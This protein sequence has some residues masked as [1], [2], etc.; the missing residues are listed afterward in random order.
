MMIK[1]LKYD[2]FIIMFFLLYVLYSIKSGFFSLI[3]NNEFIFQ[4]KNFINVFLIISSVTSAFLLSKTRTKFYL[5]IFTILSI[6]G[7][8]FFSNKSYLGFLLII[9]MLILASKIKW[10]NILKIIIFSNIITIIFICFS[11][12]FSEYYFLEDDRFGERFTA[13]FDNPNTLGQYSLMLFTVT[14]LFSELK[15]KEITTRLFIVSVIFIIILT[16]LYLTYSRTSLLLSV[17]FYFLFL[18]CTIY[19]K[20][21][22]FL[23]RK[24]IKTLLF[25]F[26]FSIIII[27]FYF[28]LFFKIDSFLYEVNDLLT[29]RLW[30]GN[31]LFNSIGF[32]NFFIGTN[33]EEYLP[34]DFYFIQIIYS[35][36][37]IPFSI[38]Y[39]M[40]TKKFFNTKITLLMGCTLFVMLLET[41]TETY[42][43][44]PFYS[45][46]LFIIYSKKI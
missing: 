40:I 1:N 23:P 44:V 8:F 18:I 16:I 34:I 10:E 29:S 33:I 39:F 45:I 13:G 20:S 30:F 43:S 28:I 17:L 35:F 3:I 5:A 27:Q 31:I 12:Y 38:L 42:F 41:M 46:A 19:K 32:P 11:A 36:G 15:I 26:S 7:L 37:L 6:I 24:K 22:Q 25:L 2:P 21:N 9:S 14:A 4:I